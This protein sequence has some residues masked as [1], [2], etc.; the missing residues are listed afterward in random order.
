MIHVDVNKVDVDDAK[1]DD[2]GQHLLLQLSGPAPIPGEVDQLG[3]QQVKLSQFSP[4]S[5][6]QTVQWTVSIPLPVFSNVVQYMYR[7]LYHSLREVLI[8]ITSPGMD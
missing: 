2:H 5:T 4:M 3:R 6:S 7:S 1:L 8:L